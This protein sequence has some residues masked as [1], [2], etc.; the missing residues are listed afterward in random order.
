MREYVIGSITF[1][2]H[3]ACNV[4][5]CPIHP[6]PISSRF[7]FPKYTPETYPYVVEPAECPPHRFRVNEARHW[8]LYC[9]KCGATK[10]I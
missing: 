3:A 2:P 6:Q 7:E 10:D 8:Q 5:G 1:E 4:L 9:E